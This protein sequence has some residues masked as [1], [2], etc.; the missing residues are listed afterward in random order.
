MTKGDRV[1]EMLKEEINNGNL[2][3]GEKLLSEVELC[4]KYKVSR[5]T[6]RSAIHT[7]AVEGLI[8]TYQGKGSFVNKHIQLGSNS[9]Q[10]FSNLSASRIDMF[11]FRRMFEAESAALAAIRADEQTVDMLKNSVMKMQMARTT[12]EAAEQ[13]MDFHYIIAQATQNAI[14]PEVFNT[15]RSAYSKMFY[16]NVKLRGNEGY[17]EHLQIISAIES[18]N[19]NGA[20]RYMEEHLNNSMMQNTVATYM[21]GEISGDKK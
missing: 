18:R 7:L 21:N 19:P 16:E 9:Q 12:K 13:D 1:A 2:K 15:L 6:I 20:R 8:D 10:V 11:E 3:P 17:K 5:T 4:D 14:M